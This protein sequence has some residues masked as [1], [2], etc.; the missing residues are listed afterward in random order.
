MNKLALYGGTPVREKPYPAWPAA[1]PLE[2]QNVAEVLASR[3]WGGHAATVTRFETLFAGMHDCEHGVATATGT[4]ALELALTAAGIA[5][6]DE[7]IVPAHSFIATATA[8]SRVGAIP[9]FVDIDRDT[10]NIDPKAM[11]AAVTDRTRAALIVHFGGLPADMDRIGDIARARKFA[12]LEDAAH[13][14]GSEW[15][16]QRAGGFGVCAAFSFQNSKTMTSGEGGILT[17]NDEELAARARSLND[18]GRRAGEGW[19]DHFELGSNFR[20]TALQ[21]ALLSAQLEERTD[22][23]RRREENVAVL[24]DVVRAPGVS[25]QA[26]PDGANAHSY[27]LLIG[28]IDEKAFGVNRDEFVRAMEAEGVPCRPFYPHTLYQNPL[29]S[30]PDAPPHR[31]EPCPKAEQ[32]VKDSFWISH[33]VLSGDNQDTLDISRAISKIH[34]AFQPAKSKGETPIN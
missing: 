1:G 34:Q 32:A 18:G 24:R 26:R 15:H 19:F 10:Y 9:V 21:A 30:G 12:I 33:R 6:G 14:H 17:T 13:A 29:Y 27:Y 4:L 2:K 7:I 23:I 20:M 8:V 22:R 3:E 31:A 11:E 25:F 16:G 28:R 5:E